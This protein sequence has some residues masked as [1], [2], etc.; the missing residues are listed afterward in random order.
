[1]LDFSTRLL[2]WFD[3]HGRKHL[4][5]QQNKT[6][7]RVWVSEIMLQQ[8]QVAAVIP[9]YE[10]FMRRFPTVDL[11]AN[12]HEDEVLHL[13]AGLGYYTRARN[14]H[15]AAKMVMNEFGGAFPTTLA[16]VQRLPGVGRSTAGAILAIALDQQT[17]ILDGNVKR[18]LA[19]FHAIHEPV[20]D[21]KIETI[22][23]QLAENYT[24][25]ARSADYTQAIMDLGATLCTRTK[26]RCPECPM[27]DEC[28]AYQQHVVAL[29]P[30]KKK[31]KTLPVRS[32]TFLI[33]QHEQ[34]ILLQKRSTFGIWGGLFSLPELPGEP[35]TNTILD[36]CARQFHIRAH[37]YQ[38]LASFRHTFSH[39]HLDLHPVILTIEKRPRN[40]ME[41]EQQ[42]WH[43]L[44]SPLTVGIPKPIQ[45]IIDQLC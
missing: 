18:V 27:V 26:P 5:W 29:L 6:P 41:A 39:Y 13:W 45:S 43:D 23:W 9:Y 35:E 31:S 20:D 19:R 37:N 34:T 17:T 36:F 16:D 14:L 33:I 7:Y 3:Q 1:M 28:A 15:R 22:L 2:D 42:I 38:T 40:V 30:Q 21:K 32:A 24:P 4:P 10:R 11:L 8:T 25:A 12:A 44:S